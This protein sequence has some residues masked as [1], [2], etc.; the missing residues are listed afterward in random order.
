MNTEIKFDF[1]GILGNLVIRQNIDT[2]SYSGV[3]SDSRKVEENS[4][5]VA[6]KGTVSDG[7]EYICSAVAKGAKAVV[8]RHLPDGVP[9]VEVKDSALACAL[10]HRHFYGCPD[11]DLALFGVTGTNGKTTSAFLIEHIFSYCGTPCGLLSTIEWRLGNCKE[12]ADCTT[13]DSAGLYQAFSRVRDAG[14]KACAFELSS[15]ALHQNRAGGVRLR[16]AVLTNITRDHLDYH[17]TAEN[18]FQAKKLAFTKLLDPDYGAAVINVDDQGGERMARE[19][20]GICRTVTFGS[21]PAADW[22]LSDVRCS[23]E[24]SSFSLKNYQKELKISTS[25]FGRH[26]I[27]NLAGAILL[28]LDCGL[29]EDKVIEAVANFIRI[30]GRLERYVDSDGVF[31]FVDYAHT[32]DALERVLSTLRSNTSGRLFSVFGA[33]GN[34]DR[35][36]RPQM[37]LAAAEHADVVI[38]TSDNPRNEN[39]QDIIDEIVAGIP[40]G[41]EYIVI[42]DRREAIRYAA[43]NSRNSD[44][45]LISGKGHEDYQEIS[46]VRYDFSDAVELGKILE[47]LNK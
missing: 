39:P 28:A 14:L 13:P 4:I 11:N 45:V 7:H 6:I 22:I 32:P 24:K 30:P 15:H 36:K 42:P 3:F 19:L 44:V 8:A 21:T 17:G 38:V 27:E 23:I 35:G 16:G 33:G 5:F 47:E 20:A 18:Y 12:K 1:R 41:K 2:G 10:L 29:P 9:G 37:G 46:G 43:S 31:Y 34:R 26:N 40:A 25:L